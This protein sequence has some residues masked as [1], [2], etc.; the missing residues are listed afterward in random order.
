MVFENGRLR[1]VGIGGTVREAG[2]VIP[3]T[4][5]YHG[6]LAGVTRN[7]LDCIHLL[8]RDGRPYLQGRVVG[9]IRTAGDAGNTTGEGS[10]R[11]PE[12]LGRLVVEMAEGSSPGRDAAGR[13]FESV[14]VAL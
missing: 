1:V 10:G 14:G 4:A 3:S 2:A 11:R 5:A 9:L 12:R 13:R 7:A 8:G 6:T